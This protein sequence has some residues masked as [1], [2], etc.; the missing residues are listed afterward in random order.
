MNDII[1]LGTI[2]ADIGISL[3]NNKKEI[4]SKTLSERFIMESFDKLSSVNGKNK[5]ILDVT[6]YDFCMEVSDYGI[7]GSLWDFGKE[8][9]TG[10]EV[11]LK[12]IPIEQETV[13]ICEIF[14]INP[15]VSPS[16]NVYILSVKSG[17]D[18]IKECKSRGICATVIGKEIKGN[19]RVIV[20]G[21]ERRFLTP[22]DREDYFKSRLSI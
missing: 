5:E 8:R 17:Y 21:D 19:D 11:D 16:K 15:Y 12:E 2:A 3:I 6:D 7:F 14:D 10:I 9:N 18:F 22:T 4:L 1:I 20:N 13:E